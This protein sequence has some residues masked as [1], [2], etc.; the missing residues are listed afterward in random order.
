MKI[1]LRSRSFFLIFI[2][3]F[4]F[5]AQFSFAEQDASVD[6][7]LMLTSKYLSSSPEKAIPVLEQLQSLKLTLN[8]KQTEKLY[9]YK[10]SSLGFRGLHKERVSYVLSVLSQVSNPS[11]RTKLLYELS[12]AYTVQGEYENALKSVNE[13]MILLPE[14]IDIQAKVNT[15]QSAIN[16]L[17]S[18]RV[19]DEAEEYAERMLAL[20]F[21][22]RDFYARCIG[23]VDKI[24]IGFL[25]G[26]RLHARSLLPTA[27]KFCGENGFLHHAL[28]VQTL[29]AIDLINTGD[30]VS[31]IDVGIPLVAEFSKNNQSSDNLF[32]MEEA[33]ARAYL[34]LGNL[35]QAERFALQAYHHANSGAVFELLEK[36]SET[37]AK[38]KRAQGD[39]VSALDYYDINL[40]L[41]K[42]VLND[43]LHKKSGLSKG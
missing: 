35:K 40:A 3:I 11:S 36:T 25:R 26:A 1:L 10:A 9:I 4:L 12:D 21:G 41:K 14:L 18:L 6:E 39:M 23:V 17:I 13:S 34:N 7:L 32:H 31:G 5:Y 19:Y 2:I 33:L 8:K 29:N 24:E 16:T 22:E 20:P 15:F 38:I 37:M 28:L 42:K 30:Y 27:L 43:Q